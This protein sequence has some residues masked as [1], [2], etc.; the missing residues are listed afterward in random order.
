MRHHAKCLCTFHE[1]LSLITFKL[2]TNLLLMGKLKPQDPKMLTQ[3]G[4][5]G[6]KPRQF[7][8]RTGMC[9]FHSTGVQRRI[10][11][12]FLSPGAR[13]QKP[14]GC[15][16]ESEAP[17]EDTG[18]EQYSWLHTVLF[19]GRG[20]LGEGRDGSQLE[21]LGGLQGAVGILVGPQQM[22]RV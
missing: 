12:G 16:G 17:P 2:Q 1:F 14:L 3:A 11:S 6:F 7:V 13:V 18:E 5:L 4:Q 22:G 8:S 21:D 19:R 10:C 9:N 15:S 20:Q